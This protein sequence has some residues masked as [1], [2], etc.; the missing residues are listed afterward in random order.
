M[1]EYTAGQMPRALCALHTLP[2]YNIA[3]T[4]ILSFTSILQL[5]KQKLQDGKWLV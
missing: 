2:T 5:R 3:V 4:E 1:S